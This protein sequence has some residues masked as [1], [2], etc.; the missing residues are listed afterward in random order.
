MDISYIYKDLS[1]QNIIAKI[2]R[3]EDNYVGFFEVENNKV[4]SQA[5]WFCKNL[6]KI[7]SNSIKI[8]NNK[9][10]SDKSKKTLVIVLESPHVDEFNKLKCNIAPAPA[11][12][13]TG[14]SLDNY[15][16]ELFNSKINDFKIADGIYNV[17]LANAIQYQCSLGEDTEIYRDRVWLDL[18]LFNNYNSN[19]TQRLYK[20][21][22]DVII[23]FCTKGSHIKDH[24]RPNRTKTVI[25]AE[26]INSINKNHSITGTT[27]LRELV[28]EEIE[29]NFK[30]CIILKGNHP[31]TWNRGEKYRTLYK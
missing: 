6:R 7:N 4:S 11:L 12:G 2:P 21:S 14:C 27:T 18:W 31:S 16:I 29:S 10:L 23:N 24:L 13:A 25:N 3:C 1:M 19:L 9:F 28:A 17:I 8:E 15:F 26:Y 22:P 5:L 20:Y 30:N